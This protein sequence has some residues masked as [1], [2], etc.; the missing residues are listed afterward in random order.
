MSQASLI[1]GAIAL[2]A[3]I[4]F[5]VVARRSM[6][7]TARWFDGKPVV[8]GRLTRCAEQEDGDMWSTIEYEVSGHRYQLTGNYWH[9]RDDV[10]M[11]IPIAYDPRLPS[12]A[13]VVEKE[14]AT[15]VAD[16]LGIAVVFGA[17][18]LAVR[19]VLTFLGR[20]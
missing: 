4:A 5:V 7:R 10:G 16:F 18:Y 11:A 1:A 19:V 12:D 3:T 9:T 15:P 2:A 17:V 8:N 14:R 13:R 20:V 6:K